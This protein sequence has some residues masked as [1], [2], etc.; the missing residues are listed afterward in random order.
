[1]RVPMKEI[2]RIELFCSQAGENP[3]QDPRISVRNLP[4]LPCT[5]DHLHCTVTTEQMMRI[6]III[7]TAQCP[8]QAICFPIVHCG[9]IS[10]MYESW[11]GNTVQMMMMINS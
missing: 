8:L 6:I 11:G 3:S 4:F 10:I 5:G 7:F 9:A 2:E 1:M